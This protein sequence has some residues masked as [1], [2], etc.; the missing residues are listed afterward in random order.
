MPDTRLATTRQ[1]TPE[2]AASTLGAVLGLGEVTYNELLVML[3]WL[4]ARQPSI[5][6]SLT[7]RHLRDG[8][9]VLYDTTS[10]FVEG[11]CCPLA[12]FGHNCEGKRVRQQNAFGLRCSRD[13]F[14]VAVEVFAG[15]SAG[16]ATVSHQ[17]RKVWTRFGIERTALVGDRGM[18]TTARI[19]KAVVPSRLN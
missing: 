11:R 16:P 13:G 19:R 12:A 2:T 10:S 14:P 17:I 4:L 1:L 9:L 8:T 18:L 5:A 7:N 6:Q 3:D 15:N